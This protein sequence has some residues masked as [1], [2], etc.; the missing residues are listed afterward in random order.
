MGERCDAP[1]LVE[2]LTPEGAALVRVSRVEACQACRS[3][4]FCHAMGGQVQEHLVEVDNPLEARP[5]DQVQLA[6]P[7][8]SLLG[9]SATL[10]IL[11]ALGLVLGALA[12]SWAS[13]A[14]GCPEDLAAIGLSATGLVWGLGLAALVGRRLGSRA[15]YQPRMVS[16]KRSAQAE[17]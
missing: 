16:V 14:L 3:R 10:Y 12:G 5:G 17:R 13:P 6:L 2:R 11:P 15:A 8:T 9:A 1:G 4:A 7:G